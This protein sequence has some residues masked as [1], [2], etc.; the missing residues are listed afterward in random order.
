MKKVFGDDISR[1][2]FFNFNYFKFEG[3]DFMISKS[4]FSK[5]GGY[6]IYVENSKSGLKLYDYIIKIG[7]EFN[8]KPGCPNVIERI[9]GALLSYGNDMDN[10]DNPFECGLDKFVNL[11]SNIEFLGKKALQKVKLEGIKRKLMV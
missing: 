1:L 9:E 6:E 5:Q 7:N 2:K 4:G 10:N 11:E 3:I 8:L